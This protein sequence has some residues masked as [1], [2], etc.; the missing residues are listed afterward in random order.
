MKTLDVIRYLCI[1]PEITKIMIKV[2]GKP[3][4]G[5]VDPIT[6]IHYFASID[7][8]WYNDFIWNFTVGSSNKNTLTISRYKSFYIKNVNLLNN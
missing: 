7:P 4:T 1:H 6:A 5:Y 3:E 2:N 8:T